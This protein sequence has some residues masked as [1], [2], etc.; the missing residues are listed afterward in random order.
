M[1][2]LLGK[3]VIDKPFY[4]ESEK[5]KN[6]HLIVLGTSGSGKTET[7][8][9][10]IYELNQNKVPSMVIDFHNEFSGLASN[11]LNL[12]EKSINP[13][14]VSEN[15]RPENMV[16]E[17]ADIVKKIFKLGEIQESILRNAIRQSYLDCGI[18]LKSKGATKKAPCFSD[19]KKNI[20]QQEDSSNKS[21]IGSLISRMEPLFDTEIFSDRTEVEFSELLN[22]TSV[23]ELKDFP[24]ESVKSAIAEFFLNKLSYYIYSGDKSKNLKLY[25][26]IDEAHRLMYENSP[27]DRLLRESRK[28]GVGVILASQRPADFNE[29]IIANVGGILSFQCSLDKDAKFVA[30]Q[31]NLESRKIRNLIEPG[32]GYIKFSRSE[33]PEKVKIIPLD[34]RIKEA[35]KKSGKPQKTLESE[36]FKDK[37]ELKESSSGELNNKIKPEKEFDKSEKESKESEGM[38]DET[39]SKEKKKRTIK[40]PNLSALKELFFYT[41]EKINRETLLRIFF[42]SLFL[43]MGF[44]SLYILDIY[45]VL[46]FLLAFIW[47]PFFPESLSIE[48]KR[49]KLFNIVRLIL[50]VLL[51]FVFVAL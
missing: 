24:T 37:K 38:V 21:S 33:R 45:F 40:L 13:L 19:I 2:I 46:F 16:Y 26:I 8:K 1:R 44:W 29:T 10:I 11:Q 9:S 27:L 42:I 36:N 22:E 32:L 41:D 47:T 30:K 50:S 49:I 3:N 48:D 4:W 14:E 6:P 12:R 25:C 20:Y 18:D 35:E 28:Y 15:E 34:D 31:L 7:L 51:V 43:L 23:V 5:E 17:I 39:N